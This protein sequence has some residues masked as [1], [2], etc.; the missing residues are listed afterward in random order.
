MLVAPPGQQV[1]VM[2]EVECDDGGVGG[3]GAGQEVERVGR[4]AGEHD[5]VARAAADERMH[6]LPGR[7]ERLAAHRRG[8]PGTAVHAAVPR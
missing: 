5:R 1:G 8:E 7:L 4:V 2:L 3:K 6:R